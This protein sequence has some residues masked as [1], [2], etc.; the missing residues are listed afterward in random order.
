MIISDA[1][2]D[3]RKIQSLIADGCYI[4]IVRW[5]S[6]QEWLSSYD[7]WVLWLSD[8]DL[9]GVLKAS[10]DRKP[11]LHLLRHP[12]ATHSF[13]GLGLN[14]C[15]SQWSGST[16][17]LETLDVDLLQANDELVLNKVVVGRAFTYQP[18]GHA[19]SLWQRLK[20]A[21]AQ[22]RRLPQYQPLALTVEGSQDQKLK[23]AVLGIS[24]MA[25][26]ESSSLSR[27]ILP[28]HSANDG[29]FY[30]LLVAPLSIMQMLRAVVAESMRSAS[31]QTG[32]LGILRVAGLRVHA[33]RS[34]RYS[35][36]EQVH[37]AS[38]L[39]LTVLKGAVRLA[40]PEASGWEHCQM[41]GRSSWRVQALPSSA[42]TVTALTAKPLPLIRHA[43][44]EDFR[45][46][47]QTLRDNARITSGYV[48]FMILSVLL[49]GFGLYADSAPVIIGAMI[50]APL[51]APIV[52]L[53]MGLTRQD[54]QLMKS[55]AQTVLIGVLVA[56]GVSMVLSFLLPLT[57]ETSE[58][59]ARLR[60]TL[61]DLGVAILSGIAGAY[62]HARS[63]AAKS[64]AGVAIA[65]ALVPPLAV[66]GIGLGWFSADVALGALLLF[67]T[68]L[69]GIVFAASL[70]FLLL[71]FA[72]FARARKG[73]MTSAIAV[74][75]VSI[76]LAFSFQQLARE[77]A[78]VDLFQQ[79]SSPSLDVR[80]VRV[81]SSG[82]P[83]QIRL[84]IVRRD[85]ADSVRIQALKQAL[86]DRLSQPVLLEVTWIDQY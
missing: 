1:V 49:A 59:S 53:A 71:G 50:L 60:P 67:I 10:L 8:T 55:S 69:A 43:S 7:D 29:L 11:R 57:L 56:L 25:H 52:S 13:R 28:D 6:Q 41:A 32:F 85:N 80:S 9:R 26:A 4:S 23:T 74:L 70:T 30:A 82:Q 40:V 38:V 14:R 84:D 33:L 3:T 18:G 42:E 34:F 62:A 75:L 68:N 22:L 63:E 76:P 72:P 19:H 79:V 21:W 46:L 20:I 77:A 24:L 81:L 17:S 66:S 83:V 5:P 64:L 39:D 45:E 35:V 44:A 73:L 27:S 16:E 78:I 51:M 54:F 37:Q 15:P 58:I 65:V 86:E 31:Q 48:V 47:Y 12:D 61:L 36:D 2:E